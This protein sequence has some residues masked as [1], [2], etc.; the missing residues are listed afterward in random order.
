MPDSL[1]ERAG[2]VARGLGSLLFVLEDVLDG[3][4]ELLALVERE[5]GRLRRLNLPA[6]PPPRHP[7]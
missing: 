3:L 6:P 1:L 2:S 4:A 7:S 5:R